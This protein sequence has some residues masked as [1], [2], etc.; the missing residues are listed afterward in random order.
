MKKI[1]IIFW[2]IY[3]NIS[4]A[5]AQTQI[6]EGTE[7]NGLQGLIQKWL[8]VDNSLP[9]ITMS[10]TID[11]IKYNNNGNWYDDLDWL[12]YIRPDNTYNWTMRNSL[13]QRNSDNMIEYE[14]KSRRTDI[15]NYFSPGEKI[16]AKGYWVEDT[17][18]GATNFDKPARKEIKIVR[19][20]PRLIEI[21]GK[22]ELHPLFMF[23]TGTTIDKAN[24]I[25]LRGIN[26]NNTSTI[27]I[28]QDASRRFYHTEYERII[29]TFSFNGNEQTEPMS[30]INI[31]SQM[32]GNLPV[33]IYKEST[34]IKGGATAILDHE[35]EKLYHTVNIPPYNSGQGG[36]Y[37]G[38]F[39]C[40]EQNILA[41][42]IK[43][44]LIS[45][46]SPN[47]DELQIEVRLILG[48]T[49]IGSLSNNNWYW[50]ENMLDGEPLWLSTANTST[51]SYNLHYAPARHSQ[52]SWGLNLVANSRPWGWTPTSTTTATE[53][54][55]A[56]TSTTFYVVPSQVAYQLEPK[57]KNFC[58]TSIPAG[59]R[60]IGLR[61]G[62]TIKI[63]EALNPFAKITE[64]NWYLKVLKDGSGMSVPSPIEVRINQNTRAIS[65][66]NVQL[67]PT[68]KS[69][70]LEFPTTSTLTPPIAIQSK[71][72]CQIIFRGR[73]NLGEIVEFETYELFGESGFC[74]NTPKPIKLYE[75]LPK[76]IIAIKKLNES[77]LLDTKFPSCP[78]LCP[79][80]GITDSVQYESFFEI[81]DLLD[82]VKGEPKLFIESYLKLIGGKNINYKEWQMLAKASNYASRINPIK[83]VSNKPHSTAK[84]YEINKSR[85]L[86][87][88][89]K[90]YFLKDPNEKRTHRFWKK[91]K[92]NREKR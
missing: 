37:L 90:I 28:P 77:G 81:Y 83:T 74:D 43:P 19:G 16:V 65:S 89:T 4:I 57:F 53:R 49:N 38:E 67:D 22:T 52:S 15:R 39:S 31:D 10:G 24:I 44:K 86:K 55:F 3:S 1:I 59:N 30:S 45:G 66:L 26:Q 87:L 64:Y 58:N 47:T 75:E 27:F 41:Y 8:L 14:V 85:E 34:N 29:E 9:I 78:P 5:N 23:R 82:E 54:A 56:I 6:G 60:R 18:H 25:G 88:P 7:F 20:F 35:N 72:R 71:G 61:N 21:R 12:I 92:N 84:I 50:E 11:H 46:A 42:D 13:N 91:I 32:S 69:V 48:N 51:L 62:Y 36:A 2:M 79:D 68:L 70:N 63:D 76:A 40:Q 17:G 80:K 73:T 33:E